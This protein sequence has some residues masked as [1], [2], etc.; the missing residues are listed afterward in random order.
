MYIRGFRVPFSTAVVHYRGMPDP[1][2]TLELEYAFPLPA[3]PLDDWRTTLSRA[4]AFGYVA[5]SIL[6]L[7]L[8]GTLMALHV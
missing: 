5:A 1:N 6:G 8:M 3:Q 4:L 2:P 7:L